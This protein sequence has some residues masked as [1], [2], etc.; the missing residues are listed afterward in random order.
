MIA[1]QPNGFYELFERELL[2]SDIPTADAWLHLAG[3]QSL[4]KQLLVV[5]EGE[6]NVMWLPD[7]EGSSSAA[8]Q[9]GESH[10]PQT[11]LKKV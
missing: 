5:M 10:S 9:A 1:E 3:K 8:Q 6:V 7:A 4:L 11:P 2:G